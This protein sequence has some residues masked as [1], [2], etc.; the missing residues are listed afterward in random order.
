MFISSC[1][2][3]VDLSESL[4]D[5]PCNDHRYLILKQIQVSKMTGEEVEYFKTKDRECK[6]FLKE[7]KKQTNKD[8]IIILSVIAAVII[9][10]FIF[11]SDFKMH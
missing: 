7:E 6:Q 11:L 3:T 1:Q 2:T 5:T 4:E 10:G 9:A 8:F